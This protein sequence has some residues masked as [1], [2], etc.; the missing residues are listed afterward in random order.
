M[1]TDKQQVRTVAVTA[2]QI[3]RSADFARGVADVRAG[4]H[5]A[6]DQPATNDPWDYERGRLFGRIAPVSMP[7]KIGGKLNPKAVALFKAAHDRR[8][9]I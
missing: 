1:S 6:F 3:M 4:R 8:L 9:I 7:V 2:Q 5:P